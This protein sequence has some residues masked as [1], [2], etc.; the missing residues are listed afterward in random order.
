MHLVY[1]EKRYNPDESPKHVYVPT[2]ELMFK[3]IRASIGITDIHDLWFNE[4]L[5]C[6]SHFHDTHPDV[7]EDL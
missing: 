5:E 6:H 3:M 4:S 7:N 2:K 1:H